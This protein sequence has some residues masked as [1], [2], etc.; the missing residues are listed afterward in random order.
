MTLEA[1]LLSESSKSIKLGLS[2]EQC[3]VAQ[4]SSEADRARL[5]RGRALFGRHMHAEEQS[6]N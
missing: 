1:E 2:N 4:R 3:G 5:K 6:A